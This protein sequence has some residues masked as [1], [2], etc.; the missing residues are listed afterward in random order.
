MVGLANFSSPFLL[1]LAN[2]LGAVV[3]LSLSHFAASRVF[4][5]DR[6]GLL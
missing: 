4:E 5:W 1:S 6:V 2:P 3:S